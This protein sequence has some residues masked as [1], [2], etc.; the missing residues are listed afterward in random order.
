MSYMSEKNITERIL[1][2]LY[3]SFSISYLYF[4]LLLRLF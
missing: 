4:I 2:V 1:A 3:E